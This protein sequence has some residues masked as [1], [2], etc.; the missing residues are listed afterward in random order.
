M[1]P[2]H[3]RDYLTGVLGALML[4]GAAG[5]ARAQTVITTSSTY[6]VDTTGTVG[7]TAVRVTASNINVILDANINGADGPN[8]A[9]GGANNGTIGYSAVGNTMV[10]TTL[11]LNAGK[12]FRGGNGGNGGNGAGTNGGNGVV[13]G[14]GLTTSANN[15]NFFVNG[16]VIGGDGGNGGAGNGGNNQG[17][18]GGQGGSG[19]TVGGSDGATNVTIT[20]TITGGNGG[21]GGTSVGSANNAAGGLG[22]NA[23]SVSNAMNN[24]LITGTAVM[25]GGNGG[26]VGTGGGGSAG[27]AGGAGDA[28]IN[29]IGVNNIT[30]QQG[31][32]LTGGSAVAFNGSA[33]QNTGIVDTLINGGTMIG[34]NNGTGAAIKA[35]ANI[36]NFTNQSTG[37]IGHET[38]SG[39]G[40]FV[41]N[42][43]GPAT[44]S[45]LI[46]QGIIQSASGDAILMSA[47][48]VISS[49]NN[50]GTIRGVTTG[51]A[52]NLSGILSDLTNSGLISSGTGPAIDILAGST[53]DPTITNTGGTITSATVS[54]TSGTIAYATDLGGTSITGGSITNTGGGNAIYSATTQTGALTLQDVNISGTIRG[55]A[56]VQNITLAGS[57]AL[58]GNLDL[59]AGANIFT[60][61]GNYTGTSNFGATAGTLAFNIGSA[62]NA[63]LN[64]VQ[65][66]SNNITTLTAASN[67]R[68]QLNQNFTAS[69]AIT[70]NGTIGI[71]AGKVLTAAT[72]NA[73]TAGNQ[74]TFDIDG[75]GTAGTLIL[76]GGNIDFT[77]SAVAVNAASNL[78]SSGTDI[79]I[80][81]GTTAATLASL[82][83]TRAVGSSATLSYRIYRGDSANITAPGAD[84]SRVYVEVDKTAL[85]TLPLPSNAQGIGAVF[86]RIGTTTDTSLSALQLRVQNA[87]SVD[88]I[89]TILTDLLPAETAPVITTASSLRHDV[90]TV[91]S[92]RMSYLR[93]AS[94][95]ADNLSNRFW[96]EGFG[97]IGHHN[98][99]QGTTGYQTKSNGVSVG[100]D[101]D[102]ILDNSIIGAAMTLS[103]SD[104]DSS[105][106]SKTDITGRS[107]TLYADRALTDR[108]RIG[109]TLGYGQ[110]VNESYRTVLGA[111]VTGKYNADYWSAGAMAEHRIPMGTG[112]FLTPGVSVNYDYLAMD[113]YTERGPAALTIQDHD[114]D[115]LELGVKSDAR[116][117]SETANGA[118]IEPY[119][120]IGFRY[121][122]LDPGTKTTA[123]FAASP[124][125]GTFVT[126]AD[127]PSR[128]TITLGGGVDFYSNLNWEISAGYTMERQSDFLSHQGRVRASLRF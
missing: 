119:L 13:G 45:S 122:A 2:R 30:I 17:G 87:G 84:A 124:A 100:A 127:G 8:G 69:G 95:A 44:I 16:T 26:A 64:A 54:G 50:T 110:S 57:T 35:R 5:P 58:N 59:G 66:A 99:R 94:A 86:D 31:A 113:G 12:T 51:R 29:Q 9:N 71:A 70:N 24:I 65:A 7:N 111:P 38:G 67:G 118:K 68:L 63:T 55:G 53:I 102:E 46:N 112:A 123:N 27:T 73:G 49:L 126:T 103:F 72:M 47:N 34:G 89:N 82:N 90:Q 78:L 92:G 11:T 106:D 121:N 83:G 1:L 14:V 6:S 116:W 93:G 91:V 105:D 108:T 36:T 4:I 76:T 52:I 22:G 74:W 101:S 40:L 77:N 79:L 107:L 42:G 114:T 97:R 28:L 60:L 98:T 48:N 3:K 125:A 109:A 104:I 15:N 85:S 10:G 23:M 120:T 61:N 33:Y 18:S 56:N 21:N 20:S 128:G 25:T 75:G 117:I 32:I 37:V 39:S 80:A 81:D 62:A 43:T 19:I 115:L 88:D 96:M 41:F